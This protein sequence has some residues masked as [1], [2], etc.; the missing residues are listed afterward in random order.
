MPAPNQ[1]FKLRANCLPLVRISFYYIG[2]RQRQALIAAHKR[3][4]PIIGELIRAEMKENWWRYILVSVPL[5]WCGMSFGGWLS[6][7]L[8]PLFA[9]ALV[10]AFRRSK[11][12]FLLY[13]APALVMLGLHAAIANHYT[14]HN[15][16]LIGAFSAGST[17]DPVRLRAAL[18]RSPP[19]IPNQPA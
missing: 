16:I 11:P 9:L 18:A 3:L 7:L 2:S 17:G 12:V 19:R 8:V 15:L 14:R 6:L 4:A 5:T 10:M 13:A 1:V